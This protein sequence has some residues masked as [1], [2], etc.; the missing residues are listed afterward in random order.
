M[1]SLKH[2]KFSLDSSMLSQDAT[3]G[4]CHHRG[5]THLFL[6][7]HRR[8]H[9]DV[10]QDIQELNQNSN[11]IG[12]KTEEGVDRID[13][14]IRHHSF[15]KHNRNFHKV[16]QEIPE[17]EKLTHTFVCSLQKEVPYHGKL[18]ISENHVCFFSSVL[19]KETKVVMPTSIVTVVKKLNSAL[20]MLSIQTADGN[21]YFFMS[22]RN[23]EMCYNLL[24]SVCSHAQ[25]DSAKSSPLGSSAE[26]EAEF[27]KVSSHS[28]IDDTV[29]QGQYGRSLDDNILQSASKP[30]TASSTRSMSTTEEADNASTRLWKMME[31]A[32]MFF[33][34]RRQRGNFRMV[35]FIYLILL[36]L[37]LLVS[38]YIGLRM[39]ALEKQLTSLHE[40]SFLYKDSHTQGCLQSQN[41]Y[42]L[43]MFS[44]KSSQYIKKHNQDQQ[45]PAVYP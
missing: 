43:D 40:L 24:Q 34:S 9:E 36:V 41:G 26:N 45:P 16:F 8:S 35:F 5:S 32:I 15:S 6:K 33:F 3:R 4:H 44:A 28:S 23:R 13:G 1:M 17:E 39:L 21:K 18:F 12:E 14:L 11:G 29:D 22:L 37:L 38:G 19:L 20:S 25:G 27:N 42:C 2:R 31:D 7:K 30:K 10:E